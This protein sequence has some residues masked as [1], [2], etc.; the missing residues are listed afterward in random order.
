MSHHM[1]SSRWVAP[2]VAW[3]VHALRAIFSLDLTHTHCNSAPTTVFATERIFTLLSIA[4]HATPMATFTWKYI[5]CGKGFRFFSSKKI[6]CTPCPQDVSSE[7]CKWHFFPYA[8]SSSYYHQTA[9]DT[10]IMFGKSIKSILLSLLVLLLTNDS[11]LDQLSDEQ[12][13][14]TTTTTVA[15]FV[16]ANVDSVPKSDHNFYSPQR[17]TTT[18]SS[19]TGSEGKFSKTCSHSDL[20]TIL[21]FPQSNQCSRP[22]AKIQNVTLDSSIKHPLSTQGKTVR[23]SFC[24]I[25]N[26]SKCSPSL[27]GDKLKNISTQEE[28]GNLSKSSDSLVND[29]I[30]IKSSP[31]STQD[32]LS[33]EEWRRKISEQME[34]SKIIVNQPHQ[35]DSKDQPRKETNGNGQNLQLPTNR[36]RNFASY[37]CGSKITAFNS[38]ADFVNRYAKHFFSIQSHDWF[39][40]Q[41]TQWTTRRVHA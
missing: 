29:I 38:E 19:N 32:M 6:N 25:I 34:R 24:L 16:E 36:A 5:L 22:E 31:V 13:R 28:S 1:T 2:S 7:T 39:V 23:V 15:S 11:R 10:P 40:Y 4:L 41:G 35:V 14:E 33:F 3:A 21:Q 17:N 30:M 27:E 20:K 37:E 12:S 18:A 26:L 9:T 8:F